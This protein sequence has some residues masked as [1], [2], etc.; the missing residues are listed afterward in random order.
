MTV[1]LLKHGYL[2]KITETAQFVHLDFYAGAAEDT[3]LG[4]IF[5]PHR[6]TGALYHDLPRNF[7]SSLLQDVDLQ[8]TIHLWF[9]HDALPPHFV[10]AVR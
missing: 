5:L 2:L 4:P 9:L 8:T 7:L 10:L 1:G 6:L 3:L